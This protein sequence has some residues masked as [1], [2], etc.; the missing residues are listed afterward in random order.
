MLLKK[1]LIANSFIL[2]KAFLTAIGL[3]LSNLTAGEHF[4]HGMILASLKLSGNT[5]WQIGLFI[6]AQIGAASSC[7]KF[8]RSL[9][10][11]RSDPSALLSFSLVRILKVLSSVTTN[12]SGMVSPRPLGNVRWSGGGT[13]LA[14]KA[15]KRLTVSVNSC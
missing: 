9:S 14:I 6:I 13:L 1:L 11:I 2:A 10:D 12:S 8:H 7:D 15:K 4:G 5:H 3:S